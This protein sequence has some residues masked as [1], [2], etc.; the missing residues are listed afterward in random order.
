MIMNILGWNTATTIQSIK[1][2]C[3]YCS[4]NIASNFGWQ[5]NGARAHIYICHECT[6]PTFIDHTRNN[7][8]T[9]DVVFGNAVKHIPCESVEF[10]YE[11]ARAC[12][13]ANAY[14]AAVLCCRK[15]LMN[16][17]VSKNAEKGKS[18]LHYVEYLNDNHYIPPGAH[19][20]VDHIRTKGNEANHEIKIISKEDA[21]ELLRFCEML[22]KI[23]YEFPHS[24]NKDIDP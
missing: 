11:E 3:G 4:S 24:A 6:R 15:L 13:G 7:N 19:G 8:Q 16:I 23:V 17:A 2:K 18:F 12:T 10:L 14:T 5:E 9:P 20:W 1:Y 22:L 21:E